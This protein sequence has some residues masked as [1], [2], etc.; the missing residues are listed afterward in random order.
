MPIAITR[1]ISPRFCDCELTHLERVP[2]DLETARAQHSAYT[3]ALERLGCRIIQLPSDPHFPDSVFVEDTAVI[4]P[5]AALITRPGAASRRGEVEGIAEALRPYRDLIHIQEPA[6]VDGGD[7]LVIGR[8]IYVGM[9]TRTRPEAIAQMQETLSDFGYRIT[10]VQLH[11][12]LHLK[13]A[14]TVLAP[15]TVLLNPQWV[16]TK[17]FESYERVEVSPAEPFGAN[18]LMIAECGIYPTAFPETQARLE[19]RGVKM[20]TVDVSEI[21]KAEGAVTCCSLIV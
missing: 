21:A 15:G 6:T 10:G 11:D 1:R 18:I 19:K 20:I 14:V 4:L 9:S 7:V 2:I 13:S 12:C 16:D 8:E 3:H 17:A 5:E